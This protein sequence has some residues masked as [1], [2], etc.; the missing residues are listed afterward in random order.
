MSLYQLIFQ[1]L[2]KTSGERQALLH[3]AV[4]GGGDALSLPVGRGKG[5][6]E[7]SVIVCSKVQ[8]YV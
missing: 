7:G 6:L 5:F 4:K 3:R 1:L 2:V 8:F